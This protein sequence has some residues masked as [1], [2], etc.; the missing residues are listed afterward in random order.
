MHEHT[1]PLDNSLQEVGDGAECVRQ[2][3]EM[4]IQN[5]FGA[6]MLQDKDNNLSR[7][8]EAVRRRVVATILAAR[9]NNM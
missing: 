3:Y 8:C 6:G 1:V 5:H 9:R 2:Q 4:A 7:Y